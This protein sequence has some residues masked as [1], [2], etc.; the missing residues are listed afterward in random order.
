MVLSSSRE[1]TCVS[2]DQLDVFLLIGAAVLVVAILAVRASV[3]TG[4]PSLL[5]YLAL[6]LVLGNAVLGI[7]FSNAEVAHSLG[8]AGLMLILAEGGV[9]TRSEEHTSELQ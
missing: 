5:A 1:E 3:H 9:S 2:T 7:D 4:L 8:F 6:G